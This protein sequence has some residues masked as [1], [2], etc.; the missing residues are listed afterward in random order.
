MGSDDNGR[1]VAK[2]SERVKD[3]PLKVLPEDGD[4]GLR[5]SI[6]YYALIAAFGFA[7]DP[8]F[9]L[10][11]KTMDPEAL[12]VHEVKGLGIANTMTEKKCNFRFATRTK[13]FV[14]ISEDG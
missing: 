13:G 8:V 10:A 5:F 14:S 1:V 3:K 4:G 2:Y 12:D 7:H 6:K 11:D 9:V